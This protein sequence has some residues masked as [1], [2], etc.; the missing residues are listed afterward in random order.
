MAV[1]KKVTKKA[2]NDIKIEPVA[3]KTEA[4]NK[5]TATVKEE[6]AV[7]QEPIVRQEPACEKMD[8][9]FANVSFIFTMA[10]IFFALL[11]SF[12]VMFIEPSS[13]IFTICNVFKLLC[14]FAACLFYIVELSRAKEIQFT[15]YF[16]LLVT[17][18]AICLI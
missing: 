1:E 13:A 17:A 10:T 5:K 18:I 7:K 15:P 8:I 14:L 3:Q 16:V 2:K 11:A 4:V 12:C 9:S 6:S